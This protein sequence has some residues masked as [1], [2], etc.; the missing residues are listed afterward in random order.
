MFLNAGD[1]GDND[2]QTYLENC[3]SV[4][5]KKL[6]L[7]AFDSE[8][9]LANQLFA[10]AKICKDS[11][12]EL[13]K[14]VAER[15]LKL[16]RK[17]GIQYFSK[18]AV[19]FE[20]IGS[21]P[22]KLEV[23]CELIANFLDNH[24]ELY[25]FNVIE[26]VFSSFDICVR[27]K[28]EHLYALYLQ[29]ARWCVPF[30]QRLL[31][32]LPSESKSQPAKDDYIIRLIDWA[33]KQGDAAE[34]V[35]HLL[36]WLLSG[37]KEYSFYI[38]YC[39]KALQLTSRSLAEEKEGLPGSKE[40]MQSSEKLLDQAIAQRCS[41]E[42]IRSLALRVKPDFFTKDFIYRFFWTRLCL[43]AREGEP[44]SWQ[45]DKTVL[46]WLLEKWR[47][48]STP[49]TLEDI[50][51]FIVDVIHRLRGH[52]NRS[53]R[54]ELFTLFISPEITHAR[55]LFNSETI[56]SGFALEHLQ[57]DY[58]IQGDTLL[59]A[60][61]RNGDYELCCFLL[62]QGADPN[63]AN[64]VGDTPLILATRSG[65][66]P[67][68]SLLLS[69]PGLVIEQTNNNHESA[70][71]IALYDGEFALAW[72][73]ISRSPI[74]WNRLLLG[75][76][77]ALTLLVGGAGALL[78]FFYSMSL[79]GLVCFGVAGLCLLLAGYQLLTAPSALQSKPSREPLLGPSSVHTE[80]PR[81]SMSLS[82]NLAD[83]VRVSQ[84][85]QGGSF[86]RGPVASASA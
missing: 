24:Q 74:Y 48:S 85:M 51:C 73:L 58:L 66:F 61:I 70:C 9:N 68:I 4:L 41:I 18:I 86:S 49:P 36:E 2:Y 63:A 8:Q 56:R 15:L 30:N 17:A 22:K 38:D 60:A 13:Q 29:Q 25:G 64:A 5:F 83:P 43:G 1:V 84:N 69:Q 32:P 46:T 50:T 65:N 54:L 77:I 31:P 16:A 78:F 72:L 55:L 14:S 82:E 80:L 57:I 75:S 42:T 23:L 33:A 37:R 10:A 20:E 28:P 11:S 53:K 6:G 7:P 81:S 44:T 45:Y 26:R 62:E 76:A 3:L 27:L 47:A 79:P 40:V 71:S 21:Q 12:S 39:V 35:N 19:N 59:H 34:K 67:L 52:E